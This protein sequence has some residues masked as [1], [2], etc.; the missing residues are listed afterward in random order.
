MDLEQPV[1]ELIPDKGLRFI[2]KLI[3]ASG[4]FYVSLTKSLDSANHF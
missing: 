2:R 4:L 1:D 3:L